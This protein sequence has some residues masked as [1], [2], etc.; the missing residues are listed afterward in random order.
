[1]PEFSCVGS[2]LHGVNLPSNS[3]L[4]SLTIHIRKLNSLTS[5]TTNLSV[6]QQP[7]LRKPNS[8]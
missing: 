4:N 6:K 8:S 7:H 3:P 5:R 1:M 2:S